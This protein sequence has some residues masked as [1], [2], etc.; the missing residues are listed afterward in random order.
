MNFSQLDNFSALIWCA[1]F[2][3]SRPL[4][5]TFGQFKPKRK[6]LAGP[7]KVKVQGGKSRRKGESEKKGEREE[8]FSHLIVVFSRRVRVGR[9]AGHGAGDGAA[10]G[11]H[12]LRHPGR[13]A[14]GPRL[15]GGVSRRQKFAHCH[16]ASG[17]AVRGRPDGRGALAPRKCGVVDMRVAA[18]R[19]RAI[20]FFDWSGAGVLFVMC[21]LCVGTI[22]TS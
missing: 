10:G 21:R 19:G 12:H 5:H 17:A 11:G 7:P 4:P 8:R 14:R 9:R 13:G 22:Q 1:S 20:A 2:P 16:V 3:V 18:A 15:A 6:P